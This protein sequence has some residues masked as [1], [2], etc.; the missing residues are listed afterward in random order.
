[1]NKHLKKILMLSLA[2]LFCITFISC[3]SKNNNNSNNNDNNNQQVTI[4]EKVELS[5]AMISD[6]EFENDD[7]VKIDKNG[8]T[9]TV[10]GIITAMSD[11][12]K[13]AF[14]VDD[15]THTVALKFTFD[16]EKTISTFEIK[17]NTTKVFSV[18]E[19]VENYV[20]SITDLL[21]NEDN[22]DA[23]CHLVLSANTKNYTFK[24]TYS[25]KSTSIIKL[26]VDAT[27]A[28]S[29]EE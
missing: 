7:G 26:N 8:D 16:K 10:S 27:L 20:G 4:S 1:M 18:D 5:K 3:G 17:G 29:T 13:T 21:D 22:E 24:A 14:G 28:T 11:S 9:F 12:Q 25:D 23:Y 19:N 6:V 15:V 2:L